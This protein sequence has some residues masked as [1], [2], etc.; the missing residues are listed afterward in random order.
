MCRSSQATGIL[1]DNRLLSF[2]QSVG[3]PDRLIWPAVAW[4][5]Q[6]AHQKGSLPLRRTADGI[7]PEGDMSL[8]PEHITRGGQTGYHK[9]MVYVRDWDTVPGRGEGDR[10]QYPGRFRK[11]KEETAPSERL[12]PLIIPVGRSI[13]PVEEKTREI[14]S[15]P[16]LGLWCCFCDQVGRWV[17]GSPLACVLHYHRPPLP[18]LATGRSPAHKSSCLTSHI[19]YHAMLPSW[20]PSIRPKGPG[21]RI[22]LFKCMEFGPGG[23]RGKEYRRH[24]TCSFDPWVRKNSLKGSMATHSSILP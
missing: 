22:I 15:E 12:G 19:L 2:R 17:L 14:P 6:L 18:T 9:T 5:T 21:K 11:E 13:H 16:R 7:P 3:L 24:K 8:A 1:S 20:L 23:T 10:Q 4:L